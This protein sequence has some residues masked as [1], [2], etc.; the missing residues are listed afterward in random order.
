MKPLKKELENKDIEFVY[1]TN[2]SSPI[3]TWNMMVPDI[4]GEH[5]RLKEDEWNIISSRFNITGIPRYMLV[6]KKGNIAQ[7]KVFFASSV[8]ELRK[9]FDTYLAQ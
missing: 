9:L 5:F 2:Q 1:I 4:K 6:D 8:P 7:E 3:D